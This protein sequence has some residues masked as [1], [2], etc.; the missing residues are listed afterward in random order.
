MSKVKRDPATGARL[1]TWQKAEANIVPITPGD[2][3]QQVIQ[4][5]IDSIKRERLGRPAT[6][7]N[8]PEGLAK[9][10]ETVESY[11]RMIHDHNATLEADQRG[12][13]PDIEGMCIYCG[14]S[15]V[16]LATYVKRGGEWERFILLAK[17]VIAA[18]RKQAASDYKSPPVFEIFNL[19]CN[20][21]Y[22]EKSELKLT[23]EVDDTQARIRDE[24]DAA[25]LQWNEATGEYE[26]VERGMQ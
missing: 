22:I 12:V 26:P 25:A 6:F 13:L 5:G 2:A 18:A 17:D 19:K 21:G 3:M 8:T 11:F 1:Q 15:R 7:P 23:T 20:H 16:T 24:L 4:T 14:I 10:Q 9:F